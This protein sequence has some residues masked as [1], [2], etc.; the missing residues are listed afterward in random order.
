MKDVVVYCQISGNTCDRSLEGITFCYQ[1]RS[2]HKLC[3]NI[4]PY[5]N[6]ISAKSHADVEIKTSATG[7]ALELPQI[8]GVEEYHNKVTLSIR[9]KP[10][11]KLVFIN[12]KLIN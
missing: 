5:A 11:K 3:P 10:R 2:P 9:T 6:D 1:S 4:K 12:G 7:R 8:P